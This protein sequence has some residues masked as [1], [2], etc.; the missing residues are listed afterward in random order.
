[1]KEDSVLPSYLL[2]TQGYDAIGY[3]LMLITLSNDTDIK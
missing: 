2:V 1:M 3:L